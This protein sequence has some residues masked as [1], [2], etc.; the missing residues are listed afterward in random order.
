MDI[1]SIVGI[2]VSTSPLKHTI[3]SFLPS[4]PLYQQTVQSPLYIGFQDPPPPKVGSF[5]EP[6]KY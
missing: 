2:G 5:S 4:S 1:E 3:P 6:P